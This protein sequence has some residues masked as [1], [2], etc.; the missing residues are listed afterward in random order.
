MR[1]QILHFNWQLI[2]ILPTATPP[3]PYFILQEPL[4]K[5]IKKTGISIR[6]AAAMHKVSFSRLQRAI[7]TGGELQTR[8]EA[9]EAEMAFTVSEE[10]TLK[11][12]CLVMY[13][14]DGDLLFG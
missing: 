8:S 11:E 4:T 12:W 13:P 14:T 1:V 2:F 7:T 10:T 5:R 3:P 9:H 6:R